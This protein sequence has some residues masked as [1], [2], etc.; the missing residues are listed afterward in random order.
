VITADHQV[1]SCIGAISKAV[2][3]GDLSVK[4]RLIARIWEFPDEWQK[5]FAESL[6]DLTDSD[7]P[8]T[9]LADG[10]PFLGKAVEYP[11]EPED[12]PF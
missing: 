12:L 4:R 7:K 3:S 8:E 5:Q 6:S 10:T 11:V 9:Y 1:K 2:R